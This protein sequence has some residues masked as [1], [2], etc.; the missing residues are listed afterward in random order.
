[1]ELKLGELSEFRKSDKSLRLELGSMS[2]SCLVGC[3]VTSWP[4]L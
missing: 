3:A 4:L 2:G 1:M